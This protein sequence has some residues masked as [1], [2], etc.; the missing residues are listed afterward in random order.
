MI[1]PF[2]TFTIS[3][4]L[5]AL[6]LSY[7]IYQLRKGLVSFIEKGENSNQ[8]LLARIVQLKQKGFE[9]AKKYRRMIF[10]A[11]IVME[12]S[13]TRLAINSANQGKILTLKLVKY[14]N[15][16][17]D[18]KKRSPS[19]FLNGIAEHKEK[20]RNG[21]YKAEKRPDL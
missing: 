3:L 1:T 6:M 5:I 7:R 12:K 11:S 20:I 13:L 17:K 14:N 18:D 2:L 15:K 9:Y 4:I 19:T 10:K 21:E 16:P 8:K